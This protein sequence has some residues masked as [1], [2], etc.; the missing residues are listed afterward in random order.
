M[1]LPAVIGVD[2]HPTSLT[3][4]LLTS[5]GQKQTSL[6]VPNDEAGIQSLLEFANTHRAV[7]A[8]ENAKAF[9]LNL[10]CQAVAQNTRV[11][12]IPA[13]RV[14][15][16][17]SR[18]GQAKNDERDA[19]NAAVGYLNE[20]TRYTPVQLSPTNLE[21]RSLERIRASLVRERVRLHAQH[22]AFKNQAFT[23]E[24]A[25]KALEACVNTLNMEIKRVTTEI[26]H[27]VK[28]FKGLLD[29]VGV[30][31]VIAGVLVGEISD[32]TRFKDEAAF[33]AYA[34]VAPIE[35]S[36][37]ASKR[38]RVNRGGNRRL[39]AALEMV[40]RVRVRRDEG[41]RAYFQRKVKEGMGKRQ[42][43]RATKR[44]VCRAVFRVLERVLT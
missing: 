33:A 31:E 42:A 24:V 38:V 2:A 43:F 32:V 1:S 9:A 6:T 10:T 12:D 34:G 23:S 22:K 4:V 7:F 40:T 27:K 5:Q 8:I 3:G 11:Y 26:K 18:R 35:R 28:Q 44:V 41:T 29:E 13:S 20:T 25:L 16:L 21:L 30:G 37:G 39:N 19:I 36:S 17:R 15:G 14:A